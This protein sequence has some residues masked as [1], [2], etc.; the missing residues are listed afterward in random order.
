[1]FLA[2]QFQGSL[3]DFIV[4]AILILFSLLG[5]RKGFFN[6]LLGIIGGI[7]ALILAF[8]LCKPFA[9]LL[10]KLFNLQS[11]LGNAFYKSFAKNESLNVTISTSTQAQEI[12]NAQNI[13]PDFIKNAV[14]SVTK[15]GS[16]KTLARLIADVCARI[17]NVAISFVI[18]LVLV[19]LICFILKLI[20]AKIEDKHDGVFLTNKILG[21]VFGFVHCLLIVFVVL[22]LIDVL[23]SALFGWLQ[24]TIDKSKFCKFLTNHNF[25]IPIF[26]WIL[27]F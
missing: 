19:K 20:F 10:Q 14:I 9:T 23:P 18:I 22:F 11:G 6:K 24:R 2:T 1:M 16:E 5:L 7:V 13:L 15:N 26:K 8:S 4:I 25:I 3:V 21:V 17:A 12:L 27:G